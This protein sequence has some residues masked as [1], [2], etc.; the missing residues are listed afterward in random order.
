MKIQNIM[1]VDEKNC[2][3]SLVGLYLIAFPSSRCIIEMIRLVDCNYN[4]RRE[5]VGKLIKT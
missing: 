4:Q 2:A 3:M 1:K 5:T